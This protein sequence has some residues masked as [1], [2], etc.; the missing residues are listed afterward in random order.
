MPRIGV[1]VQRMS[2][3]LLAAAGTGVAVLL[4]SCGGGGGSGSTTPP[5]P[6]PP[7]ANTIT[8]GSGG[9]NFS[10]DNLTVKGGTVVTF[11]W[12]GSGHSVVIGA[13]CAGS[14]QRIAGIQN[15]GFSATFTTPVVTANRDIP[16]Y[17]EPHCGSG[18]VGVIHVTP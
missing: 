14:T 7:A 10:P 1:Q 2:R 17:C 6:P 18:M 5:P 4:L 15:A 16:F 9:L 12:A 11:Q 3:Y 13:S 8:V